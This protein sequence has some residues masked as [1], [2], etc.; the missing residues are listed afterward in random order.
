MMKLGLSP[1]AAGLLRA[2]LARAGVDRDRILLSAYQSFDWQ[3]LTFVGERHEIEFR[4]PGP[5]SSSLAAR[6][7]EGLTEAEFSIPGQIVADISMQK[8][9]TANADGSTTLHLEALTIAE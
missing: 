2:L 7:T 3:S 4:I 5:D 1:A 6:L 8:P 9:A